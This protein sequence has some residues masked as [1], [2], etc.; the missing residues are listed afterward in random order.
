MFYNHLLILIFLKQRVNS[1]F[2]DTQ[3]DFEISQYC[4]K[5]KNFKTIIIKSD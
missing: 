3:F 5:N 4:I 1:Q 2:S